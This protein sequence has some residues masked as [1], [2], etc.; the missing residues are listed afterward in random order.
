MENQQ[1]T[2]GQNGV[3]RK[4]AIEAVMA[5]RLDLDLAG[6]GWAICGEDGSFRDHH[7]YLL[8]RRPTLRGRNED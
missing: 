2:L 5:L 3:W 1:S 6:E 4:Q 7:Y 8:A